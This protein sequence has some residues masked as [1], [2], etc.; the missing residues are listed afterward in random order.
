MKRTA[1]RMMIAAAAAMAAV[2]TASAQSMKAEIPFPFEASG[3]RMQPGTYSV[4]LTH[5]SGGPSVQISSVE[6]RKGAIALS[7]VVS[8]PSTPRESQA[9]LIFACTGSH[10]VLSRLRNDAATVYGIGTGVG[11]HAPGTR[12]ATVLLKT[13]RA[14]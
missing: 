14:E 4:T 5:R 8:T 11:K 6:T 10:C 12:L 13:D 7:H 1:L 3:V 9:A 2:A